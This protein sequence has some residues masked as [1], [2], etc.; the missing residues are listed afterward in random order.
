MEK[1]EK[2]RREREGGKEAV[3]RHGVRGGVKGRGRGREG[4]VGS[5]GGKE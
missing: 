2:G 3:G 5:R 4:V 1:V